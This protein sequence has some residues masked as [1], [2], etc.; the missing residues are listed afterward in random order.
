MRRGAGRH[1]DTRPGS[2][3]VEDK[4]ERDRS[5]VFLAL[6]NTEKKITTFVARNAPWA[7][8]REG[9][10]SPPCKPPPAAP[11]EARQAVLQSVACR[12]FRCSPRGSWRGGQWSRWSGGGRRG[13][14]H[15]CLGRAPAGWWRG[16]RRHGS[17]RG[18]RT[19]R[20]PFY[21]ARV[22]RGGDKAVNG[23]AC[24]HEWRKG[25]GAPFTTF[26]HARRIHGFFA[27]RRERSQIQGA[28]LFASAPRQRHHP[29]LASPP[30]VGTERVR[31]RPQRQPRYFTR[32]RAHGSL[33]STRHGHRCRRRR[34]GRCD[35][36]EARTT[37]R[38]AGG[39][40][41]VD[42]A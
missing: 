29:R 34:G 39:W 7:K 24:V 28:Q 27:P 14:R 22:V 19:S 20:Q 38:F 21:G 11:S 9:V 15:G 37:S 13:R 25:Q 17:R 3:P 40:Q 1:R 30:N 18:R 41:N 6:D 4:I 10:V 31:G 23:G 8:G 16:R 36:D 35:A 2:A 33:H 5:I 32:G 42:A 26:G 12:V